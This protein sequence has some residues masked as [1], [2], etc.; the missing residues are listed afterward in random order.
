[1]KTNKYLLINFLSKKLILLLLVLFPLALMAQYPAGSPVAINGKLKI[2]G[3]K[4]S[5]EC[6]NPVQLRGMSSHGV[7]WFGNCYTTSALDALVNDWKIDIFRIAMYVQEGGYV[8]NPTYWKNWID[9]MVNEC[10]KRGIYCMIDWH[11]LTPGD[12]MANINEARDFWTYMSSRHKG[13]NHVLYEICNEPNGVDWNRVK[14]YADDIIPRIRANDPST[15]II[16]G[17]PTWSQDVDIA[18]NNKLNYSNIMYA[19]HFYSGT[20]SDWLRNK[21]NTALSKGIA[22]FVTEFGTSLASGDGGPYLQEGDRWMSWMASNNIS[23]CNWSFADKAEVSAALTSGACGKSAWNSTSTSGTWVKRNLTSPADNF[24]CNGG[25]TTPVNQ[26]PSVSVTSPSNQA[27]FTA[28]A[29]ITINASASDPDGSI[30]KVEFFNGSVKLGE[31]LT[32]PY[33]YSWNNV[34]AGSYTIT[35]RATDNAGATT[36]SAGISITVTNSTTITNQPPVV[37]ITSPGQGE[38][39]AAKSNI[40]IAANASDPDGTITKVEFFNGS[41]K[42]GEDLSSP[43]SYTWKRVNQG[44]YAIT[45]RATDNK[46]AVTTSS[47]VNITVGNT[48]TTPGNQ[49]PTVSITSPSNGASFTAPANI[50]ISANALDSDGSISK[51][52][53]FHGSTKIGEDLSS[54]YSITWSNVAAGSYSLTARATD[55]L[56]AT[57]NSA[58]VSITVNSTTGSTGGCRTASNPPASD[59]S[60]RN[61]WNDAANGSGV[62]NITDAMKITHRQYGMD[63]LWVIES[64]RSITLQQ[65]ATYTISFDFRNDEVTPVTGI[66]VGFASSLNWDGPMLVQPVVATSSEASTSYLRKSVTI[67]A[68]SNTKGILCIRL[69]WPGQPGQEVN[70]YIKNLSICSSTGTISAKKG[71][72]EPT[73]EMIENPFSTNTSIKVDSEE[74]VPMLVTVYDYSGHMVYESDK[75]KVNEHFIIGQEFR[76]GI[77]LLKATYADKV[78]VIKLIKN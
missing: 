33:S 36:T 6:G 38:N 28:P 60:V 63:N 41:V 25:S 37:S 73:Y 15:I 61:A 64:A 57:G 21:A 54:P 69:K 23:W 50:T 62:S 32:S 14:Q 68:A 5:N 35:A 39:F 55:N 48:T 7:Q 49:A 3:N 74:S 13:K 59:W 67:T 1:M 47:I 31:D 77:Y 65:G 75:H 58:A 70:T 20:H 17:T 10:G 71:S 51:V 11:V 52:E 12:P 72:A 4:L 8:N 44:S 29:S 66:E 45:A 18:A 30:A 2:V 24:N 16:C 42:L 27:S 40:T 53:F 26:A 22:I 76:T 9:N 56:G 43:Y 19:L 34:A 46:G 78:V